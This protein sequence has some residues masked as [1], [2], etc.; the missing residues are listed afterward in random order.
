MENNVTVQVFEKHKEK[1]SASFESLA[2]Q[3]DELKKENAKLNKA[4]FGDIDFPNKPG[5]QTMIEEMHSVFYSSKVGW[6]IFKYLFI[7]A[8]AISAGILGFIKLFKEFK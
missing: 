8:V 6:K 7:G 1:C 2:E 3:I 5:M 4:I